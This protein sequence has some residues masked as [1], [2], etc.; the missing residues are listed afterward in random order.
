MDFDKVINNRKSVRKYSAKKP[1]WRDILEAVE[2]GTKAPL[3]GSIPTVN[4]I[5]VDE[6]EIISEINDACQQDFVGQAQYL[7][8]VC[9]TPREAVRFYH[10]RGEIYVRQQAGAAIENFLLKLVDLGLG[11]CWVGLFDEKQVK[12]AL[13]IPEPVYVEAVI[14]IGFSMDKSVKKRREL[15]DRVTF[16]NKYG[17]RFMKPRKQV[18]AI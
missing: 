15:M 3:A 14:P 8:V 2:A 11:G 7:V 6:P 9:S 13:K 18:E 1:N 4:F 17:N 16:F 10:E 5:L 12:H